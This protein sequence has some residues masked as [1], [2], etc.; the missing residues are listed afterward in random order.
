MKIIT[1]DIKTFDNN[2][3]LIFYL[4]SWYNEQHRAKLYFL[5]NYECI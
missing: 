2:E 4:I 3:K 5:S 1:I